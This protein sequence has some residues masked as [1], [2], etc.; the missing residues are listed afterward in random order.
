MATKKTSDS[1]AKRKPK[2]E[3]MS[4]AKLKEVAHEFGIKNGT[5]YTRDRLIRACTAYYAKDY[6][7]AQKVADEVAAARKKQD[8]ISRSV[9]KR[10]QDAADRIHEDPEESP[11]TQQQ[12]AKALVEAALAQAKKDPKEAVESG[13]ALVAA[14]LERARLATETGP[15]KKKPLETPMQRAIRI[16]GGGAPDGP[17]LAKYEVQKTGTYHCRTGSYQVAKGAHVDSRSHDLDAMRAQGF[18]LKRIPAD[19]RPIFDA[20]GRVVGTE[21]AS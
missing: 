13:P 10:A 4:Y 20:M 14:M 12:E 5:A 6:E 7:S 17:P 8:E 18:E 11:L 21:A 1:E 15:A 2:Y 3:D 9:M 16:A 19:Q